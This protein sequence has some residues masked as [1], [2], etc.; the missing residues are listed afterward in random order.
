MA[1]N[2]KQAVRISALSTTYVQ[3]RVSATEGGVAS[4]P[5]SGTVSFA[6]VP[7]EA[8]N[9]SPAAS[10]WVSGS[11]DTGTDGYWAKCLVGPDGVAVLAAGS[12]D[13][14]VRVSKTPET[15]ID[16]VGALSI[17]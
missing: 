12:Y 9:E 16:R 14:W 17:Y 5:T 3:C 8:D 7:E 1:I 13:V 6:F 4:N 11:W 2:F 10:A 15:V